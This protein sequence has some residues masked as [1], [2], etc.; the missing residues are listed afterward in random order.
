MKTLAITKTVHPQS[1]KE[2]TAIEI[3][4]RTFIYSDKRG[5]DRYAMISQ[6][7]A[8]EVIDT[9]P[10]KIGRGN[11]VEQGKEI[12]FPERMKNSEVRLSW[13]FFGKGEYELLIHDGSDHVWTS[14]TISINE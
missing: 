3:L 10:V 6:E 12:Y 11:I 9:F 13:N 14:N 2:V 7:F 1:K 4:G 8:K 5:V